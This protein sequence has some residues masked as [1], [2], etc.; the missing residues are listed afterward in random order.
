VVHSDLN[1]DWRTFD[2]DRD[3][4][5]MKERA[6]SMDVVGRALQAFKA[7]GG[8]LLLYHGWSDPFLPPQNT[9]NYYTSVLAKMGPGPE[10]WIRL[11]MEPGMLHCG[12][13]P[14]PSQFNAV[15]ALERWPESD[16]APDTKNARL[17]RV[18]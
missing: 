1:C 9:V 12:G 14:G 17:A 13:G 16:V 8:K 4:A 5:L 7:S 11:F 18:G 10:N 15:A 2:V 6:G 3:S